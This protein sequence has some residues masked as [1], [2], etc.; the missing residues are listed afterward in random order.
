MSPSV[1]TRPDAPAF[2]DHVA[3]IRAAAET[4]VNVFGSA[5]PQA[6]V[7]TCPQWY[8]RDLI[9]H[10]GIIHRWAAA[11]LRNEPDA[12]EAIEENHVLATVPDADLAEW[13]RAGVMDLTTT[14]A[15]VSPDVDVMVFLN[16]AGRPRDFWARRQAHETTI[17]AVDGLAAKLG[18]MPT[19]I[20]AGID[21]A[22]ATDGI[23]ELLSGFFTRGRSDLGQQR[24]VTVSVT[25][26]DVATGWTLRAG[27]D[28]TSVA[29]SSGPEADVRFSGTAAQLYL[30]LWNRGDEITAHGDPALLERWHT[31]QQV[32]WG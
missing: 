23:D 18:R 16:D 6:P 13:S 10:L 1:R 15:T 5:G 3:L 12:A 30:G 11:N 9:V 19:A 24:P 7:P 21:T 27:T 28:G 20:E 4:L 14:L 2:D 29:R 26:D 22:T 32:R 31:V 8:T 17:H 25:P